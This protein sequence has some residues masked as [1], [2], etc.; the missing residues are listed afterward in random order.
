MAQRAVES[1]DYENGSKDELSVWVRK[2]L[3]N[4]F[5]KKT[6]QAPFIAVSVLDV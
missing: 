2:A 4:Y 6:R 5:Y 1:Y 3:K